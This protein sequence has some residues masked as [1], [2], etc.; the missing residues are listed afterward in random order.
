MTWL[1]SVVVAALSGGLGLVAAGVVSAFLVDWYRIS[2]FE[3]GSGFFVVFNALFGGALAFVVGFIV[4]RVIAA[5]PKPGF[6]KALGAAFGVVLAVA[7]GF[8]G[9]ARLLADVPPEIDGERLFVS[10]ELRWPEGQQPS[11]SMRR[12]VGVVTLGALSGS[13]VRVTEDGPLFADRVAQAEGFW[14]MPGEVSVFTGR[15]DRMLMF[16]VGD[17]NLPAF[18]LPLPSRPGESDRTWSPWLPKTAD[19]KVAEGYRYRYRVRRTSEVLRAEAVGPFTVTTSPSSYFHVQG[20]DF[21]GAGSAFGI[22][23]RGAPLADAEEARDVSVLAGTPPAL[24]ISNVGGCRLVRERDGR[25]DVER[26]GDCGAPSAAHPLTSD[27]QRFAAARDSSALRGWLD[28]STFATPGLYALGQFLIDTRSLTWRTIEYVNRYPPQGSVPP[29]ALSGDEKSYVMLAEDRELNQPALVV[30][31]RESGAGYGLPIE[32]SRMRFA[33]E[34]EIGPD[35]VTHHF[36]WQPA[37]GG[38]RL[39][40][41]PD[42]T[43]LPHHGMLHLTKAGEYQYYQLSPGGPLLREAI[44]GLLIERLG[45]QRLA[46]D[47][48]GYQQNVRIENQVLHVSVG[49][50]PPY[51]NISMDAPSSDPEVMRKVATELDRILATGEFDPLFVGPLPA[52]PK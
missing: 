4:S 15:G 28:V 18:S 41:R 2:S 51:V 46:D 37:D 29:L 1:L 42:F 48:G 38:E 45:G 43:V 5:R 7:G 6:V 19:A 11:E 21:F 3:G 47:D 35:W 16:K 9:V 44:V 26:I 34:N 25:A 20:S 50:S 52:T 17:T 36:A 22:A 49:E 27:Q 8:A 40:E 31:N 30:I 23:Y 14:V 39:V 24:L 33:D 13:T 10:V 32:R 12:Q